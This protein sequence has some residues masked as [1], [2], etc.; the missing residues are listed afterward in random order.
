MLKVE[1]PQQK[2][3]SIWITDRKTEALHYFNGGEWSERKQLHER[4]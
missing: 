3:I 2:E 1:E 4:V